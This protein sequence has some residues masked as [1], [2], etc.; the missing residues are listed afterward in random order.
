MSSE[1]VGSEDAVA[2]T[3][4]RNRWIAP[5]QIA[6]LAS[7]GAGA[8]HAAAA[9]AHAE[10]ASLSRLFVATAVAQL[11]VGL[12]LLVRGGRIAAVATIVVNGGAVGAWLLTRSYGISWIDGLER[13]EPAAFADT[14]CAVLGAVAVAGAIAVVTGGSN[15]TSRARIGLP[16]VAIGAVTVVAMMAGATEVHSHDDTTGATR[17][18]RRRGGRP[19]PSRRRRPLDRARSRDRRPRGDGRRGMAATMGPGRADRLLRRLRRHAGATGPRRDARRIDDRRAPAVRRCLDARRGRLPV[20]RRRRH[21]LRALHQPA[22]H[23]RRPL[24]RPRPAGIARLRRRRRGA[25][26]GLGDVHGQGPRHR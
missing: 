19:R 17:S 20:D 4:G 10:H 13:A 14:V 16:A 25:D 12:L 5:T 21:G 6:G 8:I 26:A 18:G 3:G 2:R 1:P 23:P 11:A 24:P 22:V 15:A 7:I 9:G